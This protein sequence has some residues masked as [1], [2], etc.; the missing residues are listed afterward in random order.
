MQTKVLSQTALALGCA[1]TQKEI[2]LLLAALERFRGYCN[3]TVEITSCSPY[4][5]PGMYY[6]KLTG[7]PQSRFQRTIK[8]GVRSQRATLGGFWRLMVGARPATRG[9]D[10]FGRDGSI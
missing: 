5:A 4:L 2:L 9:F 7:H 8:Y 6:T 10:A 3:T 1:N